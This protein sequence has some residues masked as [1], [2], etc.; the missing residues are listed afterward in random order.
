MLLLLDEFNYSLPELIK[1]QRTLNEALKR[2]NNGD[3]DL[4]ELI[5]ILIRNRVLK[6]M[7]RHELLTHI[8]DLIDS[9]EISDCV[10]FRKP[11]RLTIGL[12]FEAM[13][14][15]IKNTLNRFIRAY[16]KHV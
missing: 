2:Y 5:D 10:D 15:C 16:K 11:Y 9:G 4:A 6:T 3:I 7:L 12:D 13:L 1:A 14:K 8:D